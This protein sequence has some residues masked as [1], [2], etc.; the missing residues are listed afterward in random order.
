MSEFIEESSEDNSEFSKGN[1]VE[2]LFSAILNATDKD[3][4]LI[5]PTKV[6][7]N[8]DSNS[9]DDDTQEEVQADVENEKDHSAR[10]WDDTLNNPITNNNDSEIIENTKKLMKE[11]LPKLFLNDFINYPIICGEGAR[12]RASQQKIVDDDVKNAKSMAELYNHIVI[13]EADAH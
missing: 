8:N 4:V 13:S 11:M 12:S 10:G 2:L 5:L 7:F 6:Y 3:N 9:Q 1:L